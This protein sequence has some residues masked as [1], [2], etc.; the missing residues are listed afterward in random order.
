MTKISLDDIKKLREQTGAGVM[1]CR[2]ALEEAKGDLPKAEKI[3]QKQGL[4][5]AEKK[6]ERETKA[7]LVSSYVHLTGRIGVL[8]AL[9]CETDFV[10]RT[11]DF[12]KLAHELCLQVA[13]MK[14]KNVKALLAQEYIRDPQMTIKDLVKQMIGKLGENIRVVE[15]ERVDI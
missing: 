8:V 11:G 12:Q 2:R 10:A 13:S 1:D 4:A 15:F 6:S 3:L 7:G 14:P 9:G 5:K